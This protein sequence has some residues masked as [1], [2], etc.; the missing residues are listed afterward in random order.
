M[1]AS[2]T[3]HTRQKTE[4]RTIVTEEVIEQIDISKKMLN[5]KNN[6]HEPSNKSGMLWS[7]RMIG[8][9]EG[10]NSSVQGTENIFDEDI[11]EVLLT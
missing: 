6:W 7:L 3:E 8:I 11:E 9:M 1:Q 2:T 4:E 10:K 5:L